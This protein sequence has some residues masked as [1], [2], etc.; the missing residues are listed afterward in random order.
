MPEL[1]DAAAR[2]DIVVLLAVI[3]VAL[4]GSVAF[5]FR[6]IVKEYQARVTRAES[7]TDR[8][9]DTFDKLEQATTTAVAVARDN[10][11]VA[12][13]AADLAQKS[14]DELRRR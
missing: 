8:M 12:A 14:L 4:G 13:K 3:V 5:L 1:I 11:D 7:L 6:L 10:A 9:V 2:G